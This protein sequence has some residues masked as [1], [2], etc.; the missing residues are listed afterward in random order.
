MWQY[1][2]IEN[3]SKNAFTRCETIRKIVNIGGENDSTTEGK[4]SFI[5]KLICFLCICSITWVEKITLKVS[6][7]NGNFFVIFIG[8]LLVICELKKPSIFLFAPK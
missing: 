1:L 4:H 3:C 5:K 2:E 6:L 8:N 7:S